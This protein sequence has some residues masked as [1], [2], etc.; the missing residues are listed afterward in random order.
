M[1]T[2][3]R[4]LFPDFLFRKPLVSDDFLGLRPLSP[5]G[6]SSSGAT[7]HTRKISQGHFEKEKNVCTQGK[8]YPTTINTLPD[9]VLLEIFD[10]YRND[11]DY[12]LSSV[13]EWHSLVHVCQTWRQIVFASPHRLNLQILYTHKIP[14]PVK[15]DLGIWPAF[16]IVVDYRRPKFPITPVPRDEDNVI[17]AL[18]HPDRVCFIRLDMWGSQLGKVVTLMQESFLVLTRLEISLKF[19]PLGEENKAP[20]LSTGFL[21]GSAPRLQEISLNRIPYPALPTLLLSATGLVKLHLFNIPPNGYISPEA[22]V[23][24]LATLP[25][26]EILAVEFQLAIFRPGRI[27]PPPVTRIVLPALISF[28]FMG[29]SEYLEDL[30]GRIDSP[31]LN[32]ISAVYLNQVVDFQVAEFPNFVDRSVGPKT[33][34]CKHAQFSLFPGGV[35]FTLGPHANRSPW[36][37]RP[38]RTIISCQGIGWEVPHVAQVVSQISAIQTNVVHLKFAEFMGCLFGGA[39]DDVAWVHLL[40]QFSAVQTLHVSQGFAEHVALALEDIAGET[41]DEVLL[42]LDLIYLVDQPTSSIEKFVAARRLS[43]RPVTVIETE[44]EFDERLE[45]YTGEEENDPYELPTL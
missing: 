27:H 32:E 8:S 36:D 25:R 30:V 18:G 21:G 19:W 45:S 13:W 44:T 11:H 41:V 17:A 29:F 15:N 38:V 10:I 16:P 24:S 6:D 37:L 3:R 14:S 12:T 23:A 28:R 26:L 35:A 34:L 22:M 4:L 1:G 20:V 43:G 2:Q 9:D 33:A 42:S 40:R 5:P 7:S 39:G 31:Q